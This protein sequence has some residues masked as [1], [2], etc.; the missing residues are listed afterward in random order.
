MIEL[1]SDDCKQTSNRETTWC[2]SYLMHYIES[3]AM[4]YHQ[5]IG[6]LFVVG[7]DGVFKCTEMPEKRDLDKDLQFII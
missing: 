1:E 7:Q 3:E 2:E 4:F 5:M 6:N